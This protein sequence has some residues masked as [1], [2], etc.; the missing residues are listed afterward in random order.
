MQIKE[1]RRKIRI[2]R[3]TKSDAKKREVKKEDKRKRR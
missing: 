3:K 1:E 2:R